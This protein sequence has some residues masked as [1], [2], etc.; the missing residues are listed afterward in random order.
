MLDL[1]LIS[2]PRLYLVDPM[3][4]AHLGLMYLG[5][6]AERAGLAV[7]IANMLC[8]DD[9]DN[10][11]PARCYGITGTYLD[12]PAINDLAAVLCQ[13]GKVVVGGPVNLT[14]HMLDARSVSTVVVGDGDALL[15][16]LV[17]A[18]TPW[19]LSGERAERCPGEWPA[20]HLWP[21]PLGGAIFASGH[22][23]PG[24]STSIQG[25]SGCPYSC[26]FCAGPSLTPR[27]VVHREASDIVAEMEHCVE[28]MGIRQFRFN[29]EH[30][31]ANRSYA[32]DLAARIVR[33]KPLGHG[34]GIAWRISAAPIPNDVALFHALRGAGCR[35]ISFG[36]ESAD[37]QVLRVLRCHKGSP[38]EVR[39]A[40]SRARAA[41]ITTRALLIVGAPGTT[42]T[43]GALNK[44]FIESSG[45]DNVAI[46]LFYPLPGSAV[47]A[48][49]EAFG[50]R[51]RPGIDNASFYAYGPAGRNDLTPTIEIEGMSYDDLKLQVAQ[52][53]DVAEATGKLTSR[54]HYESTRPSSIA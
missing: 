16:Q 41:G 44:A 30:A 49:P 17:E 35:E 50:C 7:S 48:E 11:P 1:C 4:Q 15:E 40:I 37:P 8:P 3:A 52:T 38:R 27:R 33:S 24:G 20:R 31:T 26:A 34:R 12:V 13:K 36:V 43:T 5:A 2:P 42:P 22:Y 47:A 53:I 19:L 32:I 51:I 14:A 28:R 25:S 10:L 54:R 21:G 18:D 6:A 9:I 46:T 23:F 39:L 45:V 29:D